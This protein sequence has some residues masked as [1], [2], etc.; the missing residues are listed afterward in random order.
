MSPSGD[1]IIRLAGDD[2]GERRLARAV[3]PHDG[4]D[5]AGLHLEVQPVDDLLVGAAILT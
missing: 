1:L 5:L 2:I 4:G 3:R